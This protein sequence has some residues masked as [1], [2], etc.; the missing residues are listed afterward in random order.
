MIV[1]TENANLLKMTDRK[2]RD[3]FP[4]SKNLFDI[5]KSSY[6]TNMSLVVMC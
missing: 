2:I 4:P 3:I 1:E 5:Y 6:L